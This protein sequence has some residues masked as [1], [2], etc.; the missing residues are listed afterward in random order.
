MPA[1]YDGSM[2]CFSVPQPWDGRCWK[3]P[4]ESRSPCCMLRSPDSWSAVASAM[5]TARSGMPRPVPTAAIVAALTACSGEN[6]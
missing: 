3:R 4:R 6:S 5:V 1:A 2:I